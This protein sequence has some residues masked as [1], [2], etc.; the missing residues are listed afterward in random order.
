MAVLRSLAFSGLLVLGLSAATGTASAQGA[1]Y[2]ACTLEITINATVAVPG[3]ALSVTVGGLDADTSATGILNS[4]PVALGSKVVPASGAVTFDF[5]VP[6]DF[7]GA[8]SVTV[9]GTRS[10]AGVTLNVPFN[11]VAGGVVAVPVVAAPVPNATAPG[12]S[13]A[14]TGTSGSLPLAQAGITLVATGAGALYLARRR[15]RT[16]TTA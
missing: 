16:S 14:R 7:I 5:T 6:A 1:C 13:L 2:P 8:H 3:Q 9:Q 10:G 11:V 15:R 12:G 4:T